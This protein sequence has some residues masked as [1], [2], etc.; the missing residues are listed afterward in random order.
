MTPVDPDASVLAD[1]LE[2]V[3][4]ISIARMKSCTCIGS[5]GIKA[6]ELWPAV[7]R[8]QQQC[9]W[10]ICPR[11]IG[12]QGEFVVGQLDYVKYVLAQKRRQISQVK[13]EQLRP[14]NAVFVDKFHRKER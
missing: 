1:M 8:G 3:L 13:R 14:A 7:L 5:P 2:Q 11:C 4:Q 6:I 10:L 12:G 9:G